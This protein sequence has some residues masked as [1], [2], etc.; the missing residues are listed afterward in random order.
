MTASI[1]VIPAVGTAKTFLGKCGGG[2]PQWWLK[3]N[4]TKAGDIDKMASSLG[5]FGRNGA[6]CRSGQSAKTNTHENCR[7][8]AAPPQSTTFSTG[9]PP[10]TDFFVF[11]EPKQG[12]AA[13]K[14]PATDH[15]FCPGFQGAL[16]VLCRKIITHCISSNGPL[17]FA[18]LHPT[19]EKCDQASA[20]K[21]AKRNKHLATDPA[22]D[23]HPDRTG[24]LPLQA[25]DNRTIRT[26]GRCITT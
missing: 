16:P 10:Q 22:P 7:S 2:V 20:R 26:S 9:E 3:T 12:T 14:V 4:K 17:L 25:T 5:Y 24:K 11:G 15:P 6:I 8:N 19:V 21:P 13:Q 1:E 18:H 23:F